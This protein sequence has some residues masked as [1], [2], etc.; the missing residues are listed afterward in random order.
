[1]AK[2]SRRIEDGGY[3][4]RTGKG[5]FGTKQV[6]PDAVRFLND[7]SVYRGDDIPSHLMTELDT[8]KG[9]LFTKEECPFVTFFEF[10]DRKFGERPIVHGS[11]HR[12]RTQVVNIAPSQGERQAG[13]RSGGTRTNN[14]WPVERRRS[15]GGRYVE[16]EGS[17]RSKPNS[18][19]DDEKQTPL[20]GPEP[21]KRAVGYLPG[22]ALVR[23]PKTYLKR[24]RQE[25][26]TTHIPLWMMALVLLGV[27]ILGLVL[28]FA[29]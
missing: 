14:G 9:W 15:S 16:A 10:G 23:P 28:S 2:L 6:H 29:L 12:G 8:R 25:F 26:D 18:R 22:I 3:Y 21:T 27:L 5:Y 19:I 24:K 13:P 20:G 4:I 7:R 11:S 17:G 1:M